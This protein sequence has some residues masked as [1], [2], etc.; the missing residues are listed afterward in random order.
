MT[1]SSIRDP[2]TSDS[3]RIQTIKHPNLPGRRVA[4]PPSDVNEDRTDLSNAGGART[5]FV[6]QHELA[7]HEVIDVWTAFDCESLFSHSTL[8]A[9]D[10]NV[11]GASSGATTASSRASGASSGATTASSRASGAS[12]GATTASSRASGASCG[13]N[14]GRSSGIATTAPPDASGAPPDAAT[15]P[16]DASGAPPD[17]ALSSLSSLSYWSLGLGTG[18]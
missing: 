8:P 3:L 4:V 17:A 9:I 15:A 10:L 2:P 16:P 14:A 11:S 5:Q 1:G 7:N 13:I 6:R 18:R 12:C